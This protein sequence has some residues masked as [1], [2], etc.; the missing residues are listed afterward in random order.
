MDKRRSGLPAQVIFPGTGRLLTL[1]SGEASDLVHP[2]PA[3]QPIWS[4]PV[5]GDRS[6]SASAGTCGGRCA[7]SAGGGAGDLFIAR[8]VPELRLSLAV[9]SSELEKTPN[10]SGTLRLAQEVF[11]LRDID[12]AR[13][14]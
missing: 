4:G 5:P 13:K 7:R 3:P 2:D 14:R 11:A 9:S 1:S 12:V 8:L 10:R 6:R